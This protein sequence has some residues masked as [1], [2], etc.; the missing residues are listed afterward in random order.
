[1]ATGCEVP[2]STKKENL[3]AFIEEGKKWGKYRF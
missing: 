2:F 3:K 1:L